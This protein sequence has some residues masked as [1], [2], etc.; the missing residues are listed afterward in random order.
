MRK[1]LKQNKHSYP[2]KK[3]TGTEAERPSNYFSSSFTHYRAKQIKKGVFCVQM[4]L[5]I[6]Q[7]EHSRFHFQG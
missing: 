3:V 7:T 4:L 1:N 5:E 2:K 6:H